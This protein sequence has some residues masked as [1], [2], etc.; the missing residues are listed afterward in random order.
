VILFGVDSKAVSRKI[1]E[2]VFPALKDAG[3]AR[4]TTKGAWRP[5]QHSI[6]VVYFQSFSSYLTSGVGC[7]TFSL[8]IRCG[9]YY[10]SIHQISLP[11]TEAPE[12]PD[13]ARC[14]AR[15]TLLKPAEQ[16]ELARRD[17]WYVRPD[18]S[19]LTELIEDA[20]KAVLER[21][22][23]WL[24]SFSDLDKAC[25]AFKSRPESD[26][27]YLSGRIGCM[28]RDHVLRALKLVIDTVRDG[29]ERGDDPG[30]L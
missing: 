1:K 5:R 4:F 22:L 12:F 9:V 20:R 26:E 7:T 27:E 15:L 13:E 11:T 29:A 2:R 18:G 16:K 8:A 24:D 3:F 6:Q 30:L 19:N 28:G 10:P 14:M 17:V 25:E 21:G 23:P